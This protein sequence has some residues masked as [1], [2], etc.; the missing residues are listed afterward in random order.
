MSHWRLGVS[1]LGVLGALAITFAGSQRAAA[2]D[3]RFDVRT[4]RD[5]IAPI[6]APSLTTPDNV[7]L[8]PDTMVL[9]VEINGDARAYP[10]EPLI[11]REVVNDTIGE[12]NFA[13]VW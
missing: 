6:Y 8:K 9:G 4:Y 13:A 11:Q 5:A 12:T 2:D 7:E 1:I 10:I 3:L